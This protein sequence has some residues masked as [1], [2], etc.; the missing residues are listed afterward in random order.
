MLMFLAT[1]GIVVLG[2][3]VAVVVFA[4]GGKSGTASVAEAMQSARCTLKSA[5]ATSRQHV[6]SLSAKVKYNTTPPSTGSHYYSPAIWDFYTTP[7]VPLQVVH[8]QEH[9]GV[10]IWWGDKVP[11][12]TIDQLHAFYNSS[13][14]G[15]LGTPYP[16][17]GDKVALTAWTAPPGGL[18]QG[19]VAVCPGFDQQAF[20]AF[21]DTYRG[22]GPERYPVDSETPGT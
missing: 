6:T 4:T 7:A 14:N 12:S 15:M 13:P 20:T 2:I 9:G 21:R 16:S 19:H 18:G 5:P 10:I 8:N 3:V 11:Q 1:A 17:L 22:R